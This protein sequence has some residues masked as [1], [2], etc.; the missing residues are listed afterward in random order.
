MRNI[1]RN[2]NY[3]AS[4]EDCI[5]KKPPTG[6][7]VLVFYFN[8]NKSRARINEEVSNLISGLKRENPALWE[9]YHIVFIVTEGETRVEVLNGLPKFSPDLEEILPDHKPFEGDVLDFE[10]EEWKD[11]LR[12]ALINPNNYV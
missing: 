10:R 2:L 12:K 3:L 6:S 4:P 5:K 9:D 8:N 11:D 7:P 1:P